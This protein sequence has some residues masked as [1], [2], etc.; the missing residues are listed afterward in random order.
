MIVFGLIGCVYVFY[1][2]YKQ[3][4]YSKR[5]LAIIYRLPFYT[6]CTG[7]NYVVWRNPETELSPLWYHVQVHIISNNTR[8]TG[9]FVKSGVNMRCDNY[10]FRPD[11]ID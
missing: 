6:A 9:T 7:K 4:I 5:K 3:W 2:I 11:F 8:E 1:R 10:G